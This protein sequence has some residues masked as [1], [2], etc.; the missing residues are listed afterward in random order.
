MVMHS[1]DPPSPKST[2]DIT[3]GEGVG[4][5]FGVNRTA[6]SGENIYNACVFQDKKAMVL[7]YT[8]SGFVMFDQGGE[9]AE[10]EIYRVP[11]PPLSDLHDN[12]LQL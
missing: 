1:L 12:N 11:S 7:I 5:I 8:I 3:V 10:Y 4:G 6:T 2:A 9:I